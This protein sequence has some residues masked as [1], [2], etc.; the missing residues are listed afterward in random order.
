MNRI[1]ICHTY[2]NVYV[3]ILKELNGQK[4]DSQK[5][6]IALSLMSTDFKDLKSRLEKSSLFAEVFELNEVHPRFFKE[7]FRYATEAKNWL[8]RTIIDDLF[9][10]RFTAKQEERYLNIDFS[11]YREIFVYCDA[12]PIGQYLNYKKIY[13]HAIEDGLDA[14]KIQD[15][16]KNSRFFYIRLLLARLGIVFIYDGYSKYA[17]DIEVNNSQG[18]NTFG[19]KVREVSRKNLLDQL[20]NN[21]KQ[22]IYD[23]FF[24][25]NTNKKFNNN[26]KNI[27]IM[28]Q[29]LCTKEKR[30]EMYRD[31]IKNHG[32]GYN[33]YIKPHPI[34]DGNYEKEFPECIV[35]ERFFPVEIFNFKCELDIEKIITVYTVLN[36]LTFA[37]EKIRLGIGLL[38]SYEDPILHNYV[39]D[40]E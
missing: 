29:P 3:S 32:N 24:L 20:T 28:T 22:T 37:K 8:L 27:L 36:D 19:R 17:L 35:L 39:K 14:C 9:A 7:K 4:T 18:I 5:G 21:E 25:G 13:Y 15:V 23:I 1:Y 31:I 30:I 16:K 10:W 38:D 2:Y 40:V 11:V 6:T 33:I 34:D 12:D 26:K